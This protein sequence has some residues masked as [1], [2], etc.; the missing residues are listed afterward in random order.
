MMMKKLFLTLIMMLLV[1]TAFAEDIRVN[2]MRDQESVQIE[3]ET[4]FSV[5]DINSGVHKDIEKGRYYLSVRGGA[6][7]LN[8]N[9]IGDNVE[10]KRSEGG[11]LPLINQK[12]YNG[13]LL[14]TPRAGRV[15]LNNV[16]DLE[17]FVS[18]VLPAKASP[19]WPDEALKAQAIAARSYAKYMKLL[20]KDNTYDIEANDKELPFNGLGSE[21]T[22]ISGAVQATVGQY[23]L[24]RDG[25][26]AMA[27]TTMSTGGRTESAVNAF[28]V[29]YSYL[30]SVEDF[31][32]DCPDYQWT[33][34]FS[35]ATIRN[36]IEQ[37]GDVIVGKIRSIHL[38]P[39]ST[40]GDDRSE[41]GRVRS[42]LV[43]GE[44]GIA[45]IDAYNLIQQLELKSSLFDI[46]T[47][48]PMPTK[49]DAP[50]MNYYGVE[51]DRKEMPIN[52][53][54]NRPHTWQGMSKSTHMLKGVKDEKVTF[55]GLGNGHGVGLSIWGARGLANKKKTYEQILAH[56]YPN[57]KLVK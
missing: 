57:T 13:S 56:Y 43:R 17:F 38:S 39:L 37:Y 1:A 36:I 6:L 7:Y 10:I 41:S 40:P 2:L 21:K 5:T 20:N 32:S 27:V 25:M 48:V 42:L 45:R 31:D 16:L 26:P 4:G 35:P 29:S 54:E 18:N 55:R 46:E 51:V 47:G 22:V 33:M 28:G 15:H 23:L 9:V 49:I 30:Q 24:D 11:S 19:I 3:A 44:D 8:D 12:R 34:E 53:G 50:I 14:A 52:W